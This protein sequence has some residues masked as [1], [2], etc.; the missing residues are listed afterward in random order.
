MFYHEHKSGGHKVLLKTLLPII[1]R[2][3]WDRKGFKPSIITSLVSQIEMDGCEFFCEKCGK[4]VSLEKVYCRCFHC[5][6]QIPL[7][8]AVSPDRSLGIYCR[9]HSKQYFKEEK[10]L[11]ILK[12]LGV[13]T[14]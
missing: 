6:K 11:P 13:T 14:T 9:E 5:D 4:L 10:A 7:S 1:M 2:P 8:E 3:N 12:Y